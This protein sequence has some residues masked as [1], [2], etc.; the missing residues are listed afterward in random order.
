LANSILYIFS[1]FTLLLIALL[2]SF[3]RRRRGNEAGRFLSLY[4]WFFLVSISISY[5]VM[6]PYLA[7]VPHLFRSAQF[8]ILLWMPLSYLYIRQTLH[9]KP[10]G[11][12]DLLHLL[13]LLLF[14][15]DYFPFF[16]LSGERK[17]EIWRG[18]NDYRLNTGFKEGWFMPEGAHIVVRYASMLTYWTLQFFLL[19]RLP[20]KHRK[21]I[22]F[23]NP[24]QLRWF[25]WLLWCQA[26]LI[27]PSLLALL[28]VTK[29]MQSSLLAL[30]ALVSALLQGYFLF[31]HPEILYGLN[32]DL[33][34][35]GPGNPGVIHSKLETD[36]KTIPESTSSYLD[37]VDESSL[38]RIE[39]LLNPLM[40]KEKVF[41]NP[42]LKVSDLSEATGFGPHKLAAYFN[43]RCG[44]TFNDYI[45]NQRVQYCAIK[46]ESGEY[47]SKTLE[48]LSSESGFQSRSTFIRAFKKCKGLTPSEFVQSV[49]QN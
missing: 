1:I 2:V 25:R 17:L 30:S 8:F 28:F 5:L 13:P 37:L 15:V 31:T 11:L 21:D 27:L 20:A 16:M 9:N 26:I 46:L 45:N 24:S 7:Y 43:K 3:K 35:A 29:E 14:V 34:T 40:E 18:L 44:L 41:L 19:Y 38:N 22:A 12:A 49:K 23:T 33:E 32:N 36:N 47:K 39:A 10:L 4:Y 48:A 6:T 42:N